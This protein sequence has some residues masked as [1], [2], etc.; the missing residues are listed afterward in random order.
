MRGEDGNRE[1]EGKNKTNSEVE[2]VKVD[3]LP[4]HVVITSKIEH[5]E[6]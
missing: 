5:W 2:L 6:G 3:F 4:D 1:K